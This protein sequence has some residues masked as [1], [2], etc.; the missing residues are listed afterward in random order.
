M[1][2]EEEN[3]NLIKDDD[4][5]VYIYQENHAISELTQ[6]IDNLRV[7]LIPLLTT[8]DECKVR[9]ALKAIEFNKYEELT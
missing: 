2:K 9:D 6:H 8:Y 4:F 5:E 7:E 3:I 1:N